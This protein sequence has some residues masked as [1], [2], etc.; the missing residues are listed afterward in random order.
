MGKDATTT[1]GIFLTIDITMLEKID[2]AAKFYSVKR[3]ELIRRW[4]SDGIQT[5]AI[6]N[7]ATKEA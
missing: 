1:T 7:N 6:A 4:L 3:N 5:F 2:Q